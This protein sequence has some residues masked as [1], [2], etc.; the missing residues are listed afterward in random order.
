M[1][2]MK[3]LI[4]EYGTVV[5]YFGAM[6]ILATFLASCSTPRYAGSNHHHSVDACPTWAKR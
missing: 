6:T 3:S 2:T 4:K 1:T 5:L